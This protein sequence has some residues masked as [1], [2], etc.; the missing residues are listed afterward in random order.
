M[1]VL[2]QAPT[3]ML[4]DQPTAQPTSSATQREREHLFS[5]TARDSSDLITQPLT[6]CSSADHRGMSW[7]LTCLLVVLLG[8]CQPSAAAASGECRSSS[9]AGVGAQNASRRPKANLFHQ[10]QPMQPMQPLCLRT[11]APPYHSC[12]CLHQPLAR[13]QTQCRQGFTTGARAPSR[14]VLWLTRGTLS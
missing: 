6:C 10:H 2:R 3:F 13:L 9:S 8:G 11:Q 7:L 1:A 5:A 14:C 4:C 12:H